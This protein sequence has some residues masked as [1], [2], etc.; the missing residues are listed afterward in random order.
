ML[1]ESITKLR[2]QLMEKE[3]ELKRRAEPT[4]GL[5]IVREK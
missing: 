2:R 5:K 1:K 4:P 3:K